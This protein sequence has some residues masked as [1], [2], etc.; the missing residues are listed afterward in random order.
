V[1]EEVVK[2]GLDIDHAG[3]AVSPHLIQVLLELKVVRA[4]ELNEPPK[5]RE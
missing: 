1:H 4:K 5:H 3:V 2:K